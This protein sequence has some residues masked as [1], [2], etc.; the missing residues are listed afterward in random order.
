M[1]SRDGR[2]T[3]PHIKTWEWSFT[4][5]IIERSWKHRRLYEWSKIEEKFLLCARLDPLIGAQSVVVIRNWN[6]R[7]RRI[8]A[9]WELSLDTLRNNW[10]TQPELWHLN[11]ASWV[12]WPAEAISSFAFC[13]YRPYLLLSF[14]CWC[15]GHGPGKGKCAELCFGEVQKD[16]YLPAALQ[17]QRKKSSSWIKGWTE[18]GHS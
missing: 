10:E 11:L 5:A 2:N 13:S 6:I 18:P 15:Y 4:L 17:Q 3:V 16:F 8:L 12:P 1:C 9:D 7:K 14:F